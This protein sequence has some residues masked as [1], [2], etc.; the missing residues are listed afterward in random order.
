[1]DFWEIIG[2]FKKKKY[3]WNYFAENTKHKRLKEHNVLK[4]FREELILKYIYI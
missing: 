2:K 4:S 1:M 3:F